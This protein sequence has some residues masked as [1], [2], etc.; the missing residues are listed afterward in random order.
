MISQSKK[1]MI[2]QRPIYI[3][4]VGSEKA[5]G[6]LPLNTVVTAMDDVIENGKQMVQVGER[7]G[8]VE[9]AYLEP[10]EQTLPFDCVDM[11]GLQTIS[12][13]D[14]EQY[15]EYDGVKIVNACG[16]ISIAYLLNVPLVEV[17]DTW[18]QNNPAHYGL[19]KRGNYLTTADDLTVILLALGEQSER[20]RLKRYAPTLITGREIVAVTINKVTGRLSTSGVRHWVVPVSV[21]PDRI[22]YGTIDIYNPS[23]NRIER[24]SWNEFM[25][26]SKL[27]NGIKI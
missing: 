15:I 23:P 6:D 9:V 2:W 1:Y 21:Q 3:N 14:A 17:F 16:M 25:Q 11:S 7:R 5:G 18:K 19:I 26:S 22:G 27:V 20:L 8:W 10:Y 13:K 4:P 12:E 24:Y